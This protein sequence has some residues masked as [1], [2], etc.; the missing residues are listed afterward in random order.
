MSFREGRPGRKVRIVKKRIPS[1]AA[2]L[3]LAAVAAT[4]VFALVAWRWWRADE[5]VIQAPTLFEDL[6]LD[7]KCEQGH[8]FV[9]QGQVGG[10]PCP[11]AVAG[12]GTCGEMAYPFTF[13]TCPTHADYEVKVQ[14]QRDE[15]G[16]PRVALYRVGHGQWTPAGDGPKCPRCELIMTRKLQ[17][18]LEG[19]VKPK[20]KTSGS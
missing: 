9:A 8:V 6:E 3:S 16:Q 17:D 5:P 20:R 1:R 7:W 12:R 13:Y 15:Q 2:G 18:P 19:R 11:E 14:F 4:A 10:R